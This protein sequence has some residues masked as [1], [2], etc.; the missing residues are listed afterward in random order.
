[1]AVI[2][3]QLV[4]IKAQNDNLGLDRGSSQ[5]SYLYH[6]CLSTLEKLHR[7]RGFSDHFPSLPVSVSADPVTHLWDIFSMGAS[8]CYIFDQLPAD[9]D[10]MKINHYSL[11]EG[12]YEPNSDDRTK[13]HAIAMFSSRVRAKPVLDKI[14]GC[15]IFT[16]ADLWDRRSTDGFVK[17]LITFHLI[18]QKVLNTVN[19]LL[20]Y[21]PTEVFRGN[22]ASP[23]PLVTDLNMNSVLRNAIIQN[24]LETERKYV[25]TLD[26]MQEFRNALLKAN[27]INQDLPNLLFPNLSKLLYFQ[28]NFYSRL[29]LT[30]QLPFQ[31]QRWGRQ[32]FEDV[33]LFAIRFPPEAGFSVYEPY[34][35]NYVNTAELVL[36]NEQS[37][38]VNCFLNQEHQY[39]P[40]N[41]IINIQ[42]ELSNFLFQPIQRICQYPILL[43]SLL[44]TF[45]RETYGYYPE[46]LYGLGVARRI[47]TKIS[48]ALRRGENQKMINNLRGRVQDWKG[49]LL[50]NFGKL[51]LYD[52][53]LVTRSDLDRPYSVFLF[54]KIVILCKEVIPNTNKNQKSST[55]RYNTPSDEDTAIMVQKKTPLLLKGRIYIANIVSVSYTQTRGTRFYPLTIAWR[56][57][58]GHD[59]FIMQCRHEQQRT[60]WEAAFKRLMSTYAAHHIARLDLPPNMRRLVPPER[61]HAVDYQAAATLPGYSPSY[62][63]AISYVLQHRNPN[64]L[65]RNRRSNYA[66]HRND[67]DSGVDSDGGDLEDYI[68]SSYPS[69]GRE[70]PL[71]ERRLYRSRSLSTRR[72]TTV[73]SDKTFLVPTLRRSRSSDLPLSTPGSMTLSVA[74]ESDTNVARMSFGYSHPL[75]LDR[76]R[77]SSHMPLPGWD[78]SIRDEAAEP[79]SSTLKVKVHFQLQIFVISVPRTIDFTGLQDEIMRKIRLCDPS[80][81][82]MGHQPRMRYQDEDGDMVSLASMEDLQLALS[83]DGGQ[84]TLFVT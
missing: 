62:A 73:A 51:V 67:E 14:P 84:V 49:H 32:F 38:A 34:C 74:V 68:P 17:L 54:E 10:F 70:T 29:K 36:A 27:L 5:S 58:I 12:H 41:H 31:E 13:M 6:P 75:L 28:Q 2:A 7:L 80:R 76:S 83:E 66:Y 77:F 42:S 8:L 24:I 79:L 50:Q 30:S 59:S 71:N 82:E 44:T 15:E 48:E 33:N 1:M 61:R 43:D 16:V 21:L 63:S 47:V 46:L 60:Q 45:S 40:L 39:Q 26:T 9:E 55:K 53:A 19:A 78:G 37:L 72:T 3:G 57:D 11:L 20:A 64:D 25:Q 81:A 65:W 69:S 18:S 56:A 35:S 22:G 4:D 23:N 52:L